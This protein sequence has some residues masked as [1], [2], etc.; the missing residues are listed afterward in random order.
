MTTQRHIR[1][2]KILHSYHHEILDLM[3]RLFIPDYTASHLRRQQ[4]HSHRRKNFKSHEHN[5][6]TRL[7]GVT[8]EIRNVPLFYLQAYW[9]PEL[10]ETQVVHPLLSNAFIIIIWSSAFTR[11]SCRTTSRQELISRVLAQ[12][13]FQFSVTVGVCKMDDLKYSHIP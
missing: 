6:S 3:S 2:D 9:Y 8:H 7:H 5:N 4:F 1:H 12:G 10:N 11:F 13:Y